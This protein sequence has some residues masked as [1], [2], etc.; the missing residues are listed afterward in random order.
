MGIDNSTEDN[1]EIDSRKPC[2]PPE[3]HAFTKIFKCDQMNC[4]QI[5]CKKCVG[6]W[7]ESGKR[8]CL[9]CALN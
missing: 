1:E 8:F 2:N 9:L 5:L 6:E 7:Q 4:E 3:E